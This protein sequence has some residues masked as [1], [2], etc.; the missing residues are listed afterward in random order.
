[1][2][3]KSGISEKWIKA[4]ITGTIWAAAEIVLGSFLHNLRIP[5]SG[6]VLTAI[7]LV[8]LISV[9]YIWNERGL[10]W[11]SGLICALMKTL[12]PS[13]LIFGP[14]IAIFVEALLLEG[15]VRVFGRTIPGFIIGSMLAMSWNLVQKTINMVIFYG[16]NFIDLYSN[17]VNYAGKQLRLHTDI[18]W[19][20]LLI[21]LVMYSLFG[22]M[23]AII[24]IRTGRKLITH[25]LV[26][27]SPGKQQPVNGKAEPRR[28][29][30]YSLLWLAL[31][32][33]LIVMM[34]AL[35]ARTDWIIWVPSVA[36]VA[37]VWAFRYDRALR[38]LLKPRFWILFVIIT[39]VS[40]L[41]FS[42]L[43]GN[44][45]SLGDSLL[46]GVQMN[47]RAVIIVLGFSVLG[48]ELYNPVVRKFFL[49]TG[50]RELPIAL[51]LAT[52]SLPSVIADIPDLK[53]IIRNPVS[54][55]YSLIARAETRLN[56]IKKE[57]KE[58]SKI[59]IITGEVGSGKTTFIQDLVITLNQNRIN[60]SGIYAPRVFENGAITGYDIVNINNGA[61]E[62]FLRVE[63]DNSLQKVGRYKIF[64]EGLAFGLQALTP[65]DKA[66]KDFIIIDEVGPL[67][68]QDKGWAARACDLLDN[69]DC[70]ILIVVRQSIVDQV[71]EKWH[72]RDYELLDV[73]DSLKAKA[74]INA[75]LDSSQ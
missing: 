28:A 26:W 67:E 70:C 50:A 9:S 45:I 47:F 8:I 30:H 58:A 39:M 44:V 12:S 60:V 23:A 10:F 11:R 7:G 46:I 61:R 13:A 57:A 56:E 41:A 25:P 1:M 2:N 22:M 62:K 36:L 24:G 71:I 38:Q 59:F 19:L 16:N 32:I 43:Q 69:N 73:T 17:L 5:F 68:L 18:F 21:L 33:A 72:I 74:V 54:I 27:P 6:N 65:D 48:T 64:P 3:N 63:G 49:R 31:D 40:A 51:E 20:P 4:S 14:M 52:A 37:I 29:H 15:A 34:L 75:Y 42:I 53:T 35:I 55:L 66:A